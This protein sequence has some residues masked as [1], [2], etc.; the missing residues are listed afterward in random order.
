MQPA[1]T[2]QTLGEQYET[3]LQIPLAPAAVVLGIFNDALRCFLITA[4]KIISQ[5]DF[6]V[7]AQ[8]KRSFNKVV[9]ENLA[10][11]WF[12]TGQLRQVA[13]LHEWLGRM[14]ALCPQ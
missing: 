9:A 2:A 7:F 12:A 5:P 14:M 13:V 10:A 11:K 1:H 3:M 4:F 6:P 8:Q